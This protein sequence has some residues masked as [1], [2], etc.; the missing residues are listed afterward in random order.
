MICKGKFAEKDEASFA[1]AMGSGM[2]A[3]DI[4]NPEAVHIVLFMAD[5]GLEK[6]GIDAATTPGGE[7]QEIP[8]VAIARG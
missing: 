6:V 7:R 2:I 8:E 5:N 3:G 1:D 4:H